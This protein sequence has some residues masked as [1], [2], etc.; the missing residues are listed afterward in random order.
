MLLY[1]AELVGPLDVLLK[2][3]RGHGGPDVRDGLQHVIGVHG[4][5]LVHTNIL[6]I[7]GTDLSERFHGCVTK[8][9]RNVT[10]AVVF[11]LA[12]DLPQLRVGDVRLHLLQQLSDEKLARLPVW[13]RHID[14]LL[15]PPEHRRVERPGQVRRRN[16][17][18]L[19]TS[20]VQS[21]VEL[22]HELRLHAP[23]GFMLPVAASAQQRIHLIEEDNA[24]LHPPRTLKQ[25]PHQPLAVAQE[26]AHQRR[27]TA[28]QQDDAGKRQ[29]RVSPSARRARC[30]LL[31]RALT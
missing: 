31:R 14:A 12:H 30:R 15:Q 25:R 17:R 20:A 16:H 24:G 11:C 6:Q 19:V 18:D 4:A 9:G 10:R 26:L 13:Q 27:G 1:G 3:R 21:S 22:D 29:E 8:N 2:R 7:L 28:L 23:A 5:Q